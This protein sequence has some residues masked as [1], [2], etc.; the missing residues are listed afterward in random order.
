MIFLGK[1]TE[2]IEAGIEL[3][4]KLI[5]SGKAWEKFIEIVNS[6]EGDIEF[7]LNPQR[8]PRSVFKADYICTQEGWITSIN[9]FEVGTTA[10]Q[11]GAGRFRSEDKIDY[12]AGIQF[13]KKVGDKVN[14]GAPI[15]TLFT[16]R[17]EVVQDS[18]NRLA[19]AIVIDQEN[20]SRPNMIHKYLDKSNL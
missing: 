15:L 7:L 13:H 18:L 9:A 8:Y 3:S 17:E 6:Q 5:T 1:K 20:H 12:K 4:Q 2:S 10:V 19:N 16:D 11:L 14:K